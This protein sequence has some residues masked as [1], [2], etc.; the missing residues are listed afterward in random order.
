MV[1][2]LPVMD[3]PEVPP[4][5]GVADY[6]Q[7]RPYLYSHQLRYSYGSDKGRYREEWQ[8]EL[9]Q[10]GLAAMVRRLETYGF[11]AILINRNAYQDGAG[12]L[13]IQLQQANKTP[14]SAPHPDFLAVRLTPSGTPVMP[15]EFREGWYGFEGDSTHNWRWSRGD[16][17][18]VLHNAEPDSRTVRLQ[19]SLSALKSRRVTIAGSSGT[20]YEQPIIGGAPPV[21]VTLTVTLSQGENELRFSSDQ[22]AELPGNGDVRK[23]AYAVHNF[24]ISGL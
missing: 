9:T 19:F 6:E 23:M 13:L 24:E 10:I 4:I 12:S 5:G 2:Q 16:V 21:P 1:F 11:S 20:I 22:E 17:S 8:R 15:P 18:I 7:F 14:I 3:Y